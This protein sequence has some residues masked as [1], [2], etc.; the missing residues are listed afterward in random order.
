MFMYDDHY[1][2]FTILWI[3]DW[4]ACEGRIS[5]ARFQHLG[6]KLF[7]EYLLKNEQELSVGEMLT[8][9]FG[10]PNMFIT[11]WIGLDYETNL[12][13]GTLMM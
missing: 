1:F 6:Q 3:K 7:Y 12:P 5:G 4:L 2:L 9:Y 11:L 13:L 10:T 8:L